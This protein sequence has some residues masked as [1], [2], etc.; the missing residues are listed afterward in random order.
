MIF[1]LFD[2]TAN[3][4]K[5]QDAGAGEHKMAS[6][7]QVLLSTLGLLKN[8]RVPVFLSLRNYQSAPTIVYDYSDEGVKIDKPRDWQNLPGRCQIFFKDKARVWNYLEVEVISSNEDTV[9]TSFPKK[10]HVLQRRDNF[11]VAVPSGSAVS[12][13]DQ[14]LRVIEAVIEDISV[15]GLLVS[16]RKEDELPPGAK[17]TQIR[18]VLRPEPSH[19]TASSKPD[20]LEIKE[21]AVVRTAPD[22]DNRKVRLGIKFRISGREEEEV[23]KFIRKRELE[24][25][26][27]G[28]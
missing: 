15:G 11:R 22:A 28:I 12:F 23:H 9:Y 17:I 26:R 1:K 19:N 24:L 20:L 5:Q 25:L 6:S 18:C 7:P 13:T 10:L 8:K 27:K 21:G 2:K 14:E 3:E 16:V 4:K